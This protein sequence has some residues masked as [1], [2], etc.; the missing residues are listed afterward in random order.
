MTLVLCPETR[1]LRG[2]PSLKERQGATWRRL[3]VIAPGLNLGNTMA[4]ELVK[5]SGPIDALT[6]RE[7]AAYRLS[8]DRKE[9]FLSPS[10]QDELYSLYQDGKDLQEI[11]RS[12]KI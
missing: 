8:V 4:D 1:R 11:Q 9:P 7:R 12:I 6:P 10:L 3:G 2:Q 5:A